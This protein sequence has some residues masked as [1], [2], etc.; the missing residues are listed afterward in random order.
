V[1]ATE[2]AM[3]ALAMVAFAGLALAARAGPPDPP[4]PAG[5]APTRAIRDC[6]P[7]VRYVTGGGWLQTAARACRPPGPSRVGG[8]ADWPSS[9]LD[10]HRALIGPARRAE[11]AARLG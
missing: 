11:A 4:A 1:S 7:T 5:P 8:P 10:R 3:L 9:G 6:P 2:R